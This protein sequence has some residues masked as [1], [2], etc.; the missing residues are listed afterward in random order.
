M[1]RYKVRSNS[2]WTPWLIYDGP[3]RLPWKVVE[4][5]CGI[6]QSAHLLGFLLI[7]VR[8][9][10]RASSVTYKVTTETRLH[11]I[12]DEIQDNA[13]LKKVKKK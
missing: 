6:K 12:V 11:L 2:Y 13:H 5:I 7:K 1:V 8:I 4:D 10:K 3:Q 9:G